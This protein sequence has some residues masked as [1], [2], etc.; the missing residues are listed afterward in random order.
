MGERSLLVYVDLPGPTGRP[1]L[2]FAVWLKGLD[3][4]NV[5]LWV[6]GEPLSYDGVV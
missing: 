3:P 5:R 6:W 1:A 4:E 2:H